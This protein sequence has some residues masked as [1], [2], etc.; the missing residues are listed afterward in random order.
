[1][2]TE[3]LLAPEDT[4]PLGRS[5]TSVLDMLRAADGPLG[6]REVAQRTGLHRNT[7][8][9]HLEALVEAGLATRETEDRETPGRPRIGYQTVAGGPAGQRRYRLLAEMLTSLLAATMPEPGRAAEEAGRE[10]GAYLTEQ[11]PPY[12]RLSAAEAIAKLTAI[13]E[14]LGFAPQVQAGDRDGEYRLCLRQCPF[15]EVA[16]HHKDVICSLHLGLMRG[17]LTR[18]RAPLTAERLDPFVEPSLCI[19]RLTAGKDAHADEPAAER[20]R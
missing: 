9:F 18:M 14:G 19:A 16:Q 8:R 2:D 11:P 15:R 12:R 3:Q 17:A 7:A 6:V 4:S 10:W 20:T 1:M 5:R 13:M